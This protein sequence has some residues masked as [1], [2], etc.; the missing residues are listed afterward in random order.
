MDYLQ[1]TLNILNQSETN[2]QNSKYFVKQISCSICHNIPRRHCFVQ[3]LKVGQVSDTLP[4][5][6]FNLTINNYGI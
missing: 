1:S 3:N 4:C 2:Q 5:C 6:Q